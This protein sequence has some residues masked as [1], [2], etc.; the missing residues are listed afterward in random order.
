MEYISL[1]DIP[2][3]G[4]LS[5]S[6]FIDSSLHQLDLFLEIFFMETLYLDSTDLIGWSTV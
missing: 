5:A 2:C 3:L 6:A 4:A 1:C